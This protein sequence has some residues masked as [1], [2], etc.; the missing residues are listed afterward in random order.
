MF[1]RSKRVL[2]LAGLLL[3][4]LTLTGCPGSPRLPFNGYFS[5]GVT[6]VESRD[7]SGNFLPV[8]Q[9]TPAMSGD[10]RFVGFEVR[11]GAGS[12]IYMHDRATGITDSSAWRRTAPLSK[13]SVGHPRSRPMGGWWHL[14][15]L[16]KPST[17]GD[18]NYNNLN[19]FVSDRRDRRNSS[20]HQQ[21]RIFDGYSRSPAARGGPLVRFDRATNLVPDDTN[22]KYDVFLHDLQ[23]QAT[24]RVNVNSAGR[25]K[26][27]G[28]RFMNR[29]PSLPTGDS[30]HSTASGTTLSRRH[31]RGGRC[32]CA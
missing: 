26:A 22:D 16:A 24:I 4:A 17:P 15:A 30:L 28:P 27:A 29:L 25:R 6:T 11:Y 7:S 21:R 19:I 18:V 3:L 9:P 12:D 10:G 1:P 8:D 13:A 5:D 20:R 31:E 14:R 32:I 2:H 23:T